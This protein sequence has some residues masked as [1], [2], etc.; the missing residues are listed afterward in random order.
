MGRISFS[1]LVRNAGVKYDE[2][3]NTLLS[4]MFSAPS[5]LFSDV[6]FHHNPLFGVE[7]DIPFYYLCDKFFCDF[8]LQLRGTSRSMDGFNNYHGINIR[9]AP[10]T[11]D[12][13]LFL[14]EYSMTFLVQLEEIHKK[15]NDRIQ[16]IF[17]KRIGEHISILS[18]NLG[19]R[20]IKDGVFVK[21]V[22]NDVVVSEVASNLP[23]EI[24]IRTFLYRHRSMKGNIEKK[25]DVLKA[26]GDIL[27]PQRCFIKN[28][29]LSGAIFGLLN[30]INIRHNNITYGSKCYR[31]VVAKM[32][33][34]E[35]EAWYDKLYDMMI[36]ALALLGSQQALESYALEK[37]ELQKSS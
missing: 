30:N 7:D 13:V 4:L 21:Y 22:P 14:M 25:R 26:I 18:D 34:E 28:T 8:H 32:S 6:M 31:P 29:E 36:A 33:K 24:A 20:A 3:Y 1:D 2:E 5:K 37:N 23:Q 27:E 35:L 12:S 16:M 19:H 11:L 17:L 9:V 10:P 15:L